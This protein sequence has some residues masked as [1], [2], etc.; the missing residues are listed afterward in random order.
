[1]Q[2]GIYLEKYEKNM[3]KNNEKPLKYIFQTWYK[4]GKLEG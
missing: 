2:K 3:L 4:F 1:M